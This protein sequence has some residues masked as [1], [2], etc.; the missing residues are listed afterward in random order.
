VEFE[1]YYFRQIR[2]N[3]N[4]KDEEYIQSFMKTIKERLTEGGA[5]GAFFFFTKDERFIAKSCT[6]D[7]I[8]HIRRSAVS[9]AG[10]LEENPFSFITKIYGAY[11]LRIYGTSFYFFVTNNI[12]LNPG[13]EVINEK[14]DLKGSWVKRNSS[15]PQ[16]GQRATCT[17]CNQKF[18]FTNSKKSS[19]K[20]G[21]K[22]NALDEEEDANKCRMQVLGHHEPNVILKDNDL[23]YKLR[24]PNATS[25]HLITQ[26][27]K[28][29]NFLCSLGVMDYSL[30]VGVHNTEYQVDEVPGS[31]S[32]SKPPFPDEDNSPQQK[33]QRRRTL[34]TKNAWGS[35]DDLSGLESGVPTAPINGRMAVSRIVGP[36]AYYM[37]IVD[38]QQQYDFSKKMER[39]FKVQIQGKSGPGLSC[40][41]PVTYRQRFLRRLEE[42]VDFDMDEMD[43]SL[44]NPS[45]KADDSSILEEDEDV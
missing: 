45:L 32:P 25:Q 13:N 42:L 41:E 3:D 14:Y 23:K 30:L 8:A 29:S 34:S 26:L 44:L 37:G 36:E 6:T 35:K 39:F 7:E 27:H 4:V 33:P 28:D 38:F 43:P 5:S 19:K 9:M 17:H 21:K 11:K 10:Y 18:I 1:P 24:L 15:P 40:I 20:K 2:L 16:I 22:K 31:H 12:F